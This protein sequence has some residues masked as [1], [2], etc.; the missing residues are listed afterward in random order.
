MKPIHP[1]R[2]LRREIDAR[3]LSANKL[4]LTLLVP[5]RRITQILNEKRGLMLKPRFGYRDILTTALSFGSIFKRGTNWHRGVADNFFSAAGGSITE[6]IWTGGYI[7]KVLKKDKFVIRFYSDENGEPGDILAKYKVGNNALRTDTGET[8]EAYDDPIEAYT[9]QYILPTPFNATPGTTYW[10]SILNGKK[11]NWSWADAEMGTPNL[12]AFRDGNNEPWSIYSNDE[13]SV[14]RAF[15]L[16][17]T[18]SQV[19]EPTTL[20]FLGAGIVGLMGFRK[21]INK[22]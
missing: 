10:I 4:A 22:I 12:V 15:E 6:V 3:K 13:R 5:S 2:I 21:R 1:G 11:E 17:G 14:N 16:D 9:Y 20:L 7:D 18:F 8:F 19:P